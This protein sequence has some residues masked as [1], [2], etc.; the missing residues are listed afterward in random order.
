M[1]T[2]H[3]SVRLRGAFA[4]ALSTILLFLATCPVAMAQSAHS[5]PVPA[6]GT[7]ADMD[8]PTTINVFYLSDF[9]AGKVLYYPP[10]GGTGRV[11]VDG[12]PATTGLAFDAA[13]TLYVSSDKTGTQEATIYTVPPNGGSKQVFYSDA[14]LRQAH[15]LA[16]DANGDL[17][18]ATAS[19]RTV[20]EFVAPFTTPPAP[21]I[22][23]ADTSDGLY[24][25]ISVAF[26]SSGALYVSNAYGPGP[27]ANGS[28]FKFT[29]PHTGT[30][31]PS[32]SGGFCVAYGLAFDT[33]GNLY[34]SNAA[35][36]SCGAPSI[37]KY[38]TSGVWTTF[39]TGDLVEPLG[40]AIDQSNNVYVADR[41]L[42]EIEK[43]TPS[44]VGSF[45][46]SG[47]IAPHFLAIQPH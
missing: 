38:S 41:Q 7:G 11:F 29:G 3:P 43:F 10:S 42:N 19:G 14:S 1:K 15:G 8:S 20:L 37:L 21:P 47:E 2:I 13:G 23:Y 33:N 45:F 31:L 5:I 32:P 6:Q 18:V 24:Q 40:L 9:Q 28:V 36:K 35:T 30:M 34:V 27:G 46:A 16:F 44:G 22:V 25:P 26:D 17:F 39:A 12:I 4:G